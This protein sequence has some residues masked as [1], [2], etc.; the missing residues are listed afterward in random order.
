MP[1]S[2]NG[3]SD[4]IHA[5]AAH[6]TNGATAFSVAGWIKS[7]AK[8]FAMIYSETN[9]TNTGPL[10][11]FSLSGSAPNTTGLKLEIEARSGGSGGV[12]EFQNTVTVADSTW[13]HV[14]VTQSAAGLMTLYALGAADGTLTRTALSNSN[15]QTF[16]AV[17]IGAD[18]LN[19]TTNFFP[20]LIA[21]L[22]TWTRQLV[23]TEVA[24]LAAGMLPPGLGCAH[25]WPLWGQDSPEPDVAAAGVDGTLTGTTLGAGGPPVTPSMLQL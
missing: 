20:G 4:L 23:A 16:S 17:I 9:P 1:R 15:T 13:R 10:F 11:F 22:G 6:L 14:A 19:V 18:R 8:A 3:T 24:S 25:Y 21:H 2:F 5:D 7:T 12:D